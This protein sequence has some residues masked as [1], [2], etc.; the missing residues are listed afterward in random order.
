MEA[1]PG[2]ELDVAACKMIMKVAEIEHAPRSQRN[3]KM[4]EGMKKETDRCL[5]ALKG[6]DWVRYSAWTRVDMMAVEWSGR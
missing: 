4:E 2:D 1:S 6:G 3:V 5:A